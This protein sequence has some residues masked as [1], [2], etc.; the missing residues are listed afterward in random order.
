M[1]LSQLTKSQKTTVIERT[2]DARVKKLQLK[3]TRVLARL[4]SRMKTVANMHNLH[5]AS[6]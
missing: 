3:S 4:I 2:E 6:I 5:T 1:T